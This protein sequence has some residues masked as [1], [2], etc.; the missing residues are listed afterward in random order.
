MVYGVKTI[1]DTFHAFE[2]GTIPIVHQNFNCL[3]LFQGITSIG[4][5]VKGISQYD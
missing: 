1:Q 4:I 3:H 5:R 2:Q